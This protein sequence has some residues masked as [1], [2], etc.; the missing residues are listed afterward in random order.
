LLSGRPP[1]EGE[2]SARV[3]Q[4]VIDTDPVSPLSADSRL[5]RDLETICLKCLRKDPRERYASAAALGD[6]LGRF[7]RDEPILARPISASERLRKWA[8]RKPA[9]AALAI[10]SILALAGL[11]VGLAIS[12]ALI[13]DARNATTKAL[14][15]KTQALAS[16]EHASYIKTI[17]LA[18]QDVLDND[19]RHAIK[20]LESCDPA[21]R[22]WEWH[23][24]M[25][26]CRGTH[27]R[28]KSAGDSVTE[29]AV[30][31][32]GQWLA[33]L[34]VDSEKK[35]A[36][37][38][39]W[40]AATGEKIVTLLDPSATAH[41]NDPWTWMPHLVFSD[42][43]RHL[44]YTAFEYADEKV[45]GVVRR[46]DT[47]TWKP[48]PVKPE[49]FPDRVPIGVM[50]TKDGKFLTI[51]K[52]V[53]KL[54]VRDAK[55]TMQICDLD[56]GEVLYE[57]QAGQRMAHPLLSPDGQ[58]FVIDVGSVEVYELATGKLV[59]YVHLGRATLAT[60]WHPSGKSL[61]MV[62]MNGRLTHS[63]WPDNALHGVQKFQI[64]AHRRYAQDVAFLPDGKRIATTGVDGQVK[65][66]NAEDGRLL[67]SLT[68]GGDVWSVAVFPSGNEIAFAD[69]QGEI[70][71]WNIASQ[72]QINQPGEPAE[73]YWGFQVS[74]DGTRAAYCDSECY[75]L[76]DLTTRTQ[77]RRLS[78]LEKAADK[79]ELWPLGFALSSNGD[80][81][82]AGMGDMDKYDRPGHV[83]VWDAPSGELLH[84]FPDDKA[85]PVRLAW[86]RDAQVLTWS[87]TDNEL[88][89]WDWP[90]RKRLW[91][92]KL[93]VGVPAMEHHPHAD[94]LAVA[95]GDGTVEFIHSRTGNTLRTL[96]LPSVHALC[97]S[98]DGK[99]L[100]LGSLADKRSSLTRI[101]LLETATGKELSRMTGGDRGVRA[102]QLSANG[103]RIFASYEDGNLLVWDRAT[104]VEILSLR[105]G[106]MD[107]SQFA[108]TSNGL[109]VGG[110]FQ[111]G[112]M[113]ILDGRPLDALPA[114]RE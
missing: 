56:S 41:V 70:G 69:L 49:K 24:L 75:G 33:S 62:D 93:S 17:A 8:R 72:T 48:L 38:E 78:I 35:R 15:D 113:H 76:W 51:T 61:A 6:D 109:L 12:N 14:G 13:S 3:L 101:V 25:R 74:R 37:V 87:T 89:A 2:S 63:G 32:D 106:D 94:E 111:G 27:R 1:F 42:D 83:K 108:L 31:P 104:G 100:A 26:R 10:V 60:A 90:G 50:F 58:H 84:T 77:V 110:Q 105:E 79:D 73:S 66:W 5:S 102:I 16:E 91:N 86:S 19:V 65:V 55:V 114:T 52:P 4:R 88:Q 7:L 67:D 98:R 45:T 54:E 9:A 40:K 47:S 46:F 96:S 97:F 20:L 59:W 80:L 103:Q 71:I 44:A 11:V 18:Q 85:A 23:Y 82:A 107:L 28:L 68:C 36:G 112:R 34:F 99:Q 53:E 64:N 39:I 30:S 43:G 95:L 57:F 92:R 21:K 81:I 29:L 22:D